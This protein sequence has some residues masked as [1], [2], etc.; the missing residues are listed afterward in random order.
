MRDKDRESWG[1]G[2]ERGGCEKDGRSVLLSLKM[3]KGISGQ[4]VQVAFGSLMVLSYLT[5][6]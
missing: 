4:A 3:E 5:L 2:R 1:G 6:T